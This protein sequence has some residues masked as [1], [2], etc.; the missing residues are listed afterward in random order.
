MGHG[1]GSLR[2]TWDW[3]GVEGMQV[4]LPGWKGKHFF[5]KGTAVRE[6]RARPEREERHGREA[7]APALGSLLRSLPPQSG[8]RRKAWVPATK[9]RWWL[10]LLC[11]P[12]DGISLR[13]L[14]E[15]QPQ[16][17]STWQRGQEGRN[18]LPQNLR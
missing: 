10:A 12:A 13:P 15:M 7:E 8:P 3:E 9:A 4:W 6:R 11:L 16:E 1:E 17:R 18:S 5:K 14:L 2:E